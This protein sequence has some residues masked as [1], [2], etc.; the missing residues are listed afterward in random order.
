MA[1]LTITELSAKRSDRRLVWWLSRP[2]TGDTIPSYGLPLVGV[3]IGRTCRVTRIEAGD[4]GETIWRLPINWHLP[5]LQ[6]AFRDIPWAGASGFY[7]LVSSLKIPERFELDLEAVLE[8]GS[9]VPMCTI[10]GRRAVLETAPSQC[11]PV[12][13]MTLGRTGSTRAVALLAQHPEIVAFR[14][15]DHEAKVVKYWSDVFSVLCEPSSYRE[16]VTA[17]LEDPFWWMGFRRRLPPAPQID[18]S[19]E[20]WLGH[21]HVV[22]LATCCR[23]RVEAFYQQA[24][25]AQGKPNARYAVEKAVPAVQHE[26][27]WRDLFPESRII[28]LVRDFRDVVCSMLAYD[29]GHGFGRDDTQTVEEFIRG[30]FATVVHRLARC[31]NAFQPEAHLMRYEDLVLE[32]EATLRSVLRFLGLEASERVVEAM[33]EQAWKTAP[34]LQRQHRTSE[35][36]ARS[37]GRWRVD[38]SQA[39]RAACDES[40]SEALELFNYSMLTAVAASGQSRS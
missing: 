6:E 37:I 16:S 4:R 21:R 15:H 27:V 32:P 38:L 3:A 28:F 7:H 13:V 2:Q 33:L 18:T 23:E 22:D 10:E 9:S 12:L 36:F 26:R 31:W 11:R 40:L 14:P 5:D 29:G 30:G 34:T 1:L 35:T 25:S 19:M 39:E 17:D 8:D 20:G 24:A